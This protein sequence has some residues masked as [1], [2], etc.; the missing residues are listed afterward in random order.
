MADVVQLVLL[1]HLED[2]HGW[3]HHKV[4]QELGSLPCLANWDQPAAQLL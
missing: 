3:M 2:V 1:L 4:A